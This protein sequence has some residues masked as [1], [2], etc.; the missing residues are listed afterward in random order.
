[1]LQRRGTDGVEL[2]AEVS[3]LFV[4]PPVLRDDGLDRFVRYG[5]QDVEEEEDLLVGHAEQR[6]LEPRLDERVEEDERARQEERRVERGNR[7]RRE[8][9]YL[10]AGDEEV[11][12]RVRE[13]A[14]PRRVQRVDELH[15]QVGVVEVG[16]VFRLLRA[17]D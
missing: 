13:A 9:V 5:A 12:P 2:A 3:M 7:P 8:V 6:A 11:K 10:R 17:G 15:D 4:E 14:E 16:Q 1:M